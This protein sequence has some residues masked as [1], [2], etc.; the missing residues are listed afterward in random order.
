M[1]RHSNCHRSTMTKVY[2][3]YKHNNVNISMKHSHPMHTAMFVFIRWL[4]GCLLRSLQ[5]CLQAHDVFI[6]CH[7]H[8]NCHR[9]TTT[10]VYR[11]YKHNNANIS[12][13]HCHPMHTAILFSLDILLYWKI[14]F[15]KTWLLTWQL[16]WQLEYFKLLCESVKYILLRHS[17]N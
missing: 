3:A 6:S 8:S 7:R 16:T 15:F 5:E 11:A 10:N 1:H 17:I 14:Y 9:S 12:M 13:K 2:R 4:N